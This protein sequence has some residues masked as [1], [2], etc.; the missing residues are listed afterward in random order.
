MKR[1]EMERVFWV[2]PTLLSR[3][4]ASVFLM[5]FSTRAN[6][7]FLVERSLPSL[8][9]RTWFASLNDFYSQVKA[10]SAGITSVCV[11]TTHHA[12]VIHIQAAAS[13]TRE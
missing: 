8:H 5:R 11:T 2:L 12:F 9:L 13:W 7:A 10:E 1:A 6:C 4:S 3:H